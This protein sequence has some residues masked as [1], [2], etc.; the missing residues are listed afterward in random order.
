ML[1]VTLLGIAIL[2]PAVKVKNQKLFF[3]PSKGHASKS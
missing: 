2:P 3:F 1:H